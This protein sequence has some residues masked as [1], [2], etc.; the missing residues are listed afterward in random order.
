M[1]DIMFGRNGPYAWLVAVRYWG[2]VWYLWM[3]CFT[4]WY[5]SGICKVFAI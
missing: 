5:F 2:G 1:D 4:L 3:S